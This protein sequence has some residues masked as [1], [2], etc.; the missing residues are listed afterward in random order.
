M[1][2]V[3]ALLAFFALFANPAISA[4]KAD[5]SAAMQEAC[6]HFQEAYIASGQRRVVTSH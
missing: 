4:A 5:R 2:S 6:Y 1:R 3:L